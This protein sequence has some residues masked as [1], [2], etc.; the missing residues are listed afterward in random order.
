V[1]YPAFHSA[2]REDTEHRK[3]HPLS[4]GSR[5]QER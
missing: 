2:P 3:L 4:S 1:W 5:L